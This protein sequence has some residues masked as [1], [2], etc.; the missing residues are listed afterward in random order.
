M[1]LHSTPLQD[2][3]TALGARMV[4]FA[5]W[6]MPLQY[7]P[8]LE[9]VQQVRQ[10]CGLFD[11]TH[12]G[13]FRVSG[14]E[15]VAMV[16]RVSTNYCARIPVG[17]IR[18]SLFCKPDG[19]PIDDLLIYRREQDVY[20]VVNASNRERDYD[21]IVEHGE[22]MDAEVVDETVETV[23]LALQGPSSELILQRVV[24]D[25]D[26]SQLGYYKFTS[27]TLCGLPDTQISRTGY[28]GE[29][30]FELYLPKAEGVRVW[31]AIREAGGSDIAPIGLAAR[32]TLRLEA[33]MALY[34]HEI[35]EAH[36]PLEAGL[37]FGV[38]FH[39][40]KGDYVGRE[41]LER[42]HASPE[43]RLVGITTPGPRV[44]RQ[45]Q[46]IYAGD[47]LVGAVVSGSVSPTIGSNI[48]SAYVQLGQDAVDTA[49]ELDFRGKRQAVRVQDLPFYS[50]TRK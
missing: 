46:E 30:G 16:D 23:M 40:D 2:T 20:L 12:M 8:I 42:F 28:T 1:T 7:G 19:Y 31:E 47:V 41:A 29:D 35:D 17:A 44:P 24:E 18:Y 49:L 34:G 15:A 5:G 26:L 14:P 25:A 45:G 4:D 33:G 21:W 10:R 27:G 3:H 9:E 43:R 22:G 48:G 38:S 37:K 36:N 6:N 50:R 32:D 13:R 11:L 39:A